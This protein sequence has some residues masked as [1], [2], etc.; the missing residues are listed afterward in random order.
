M[1]AAPVAKTAQEKIIREYFSDIPIMAEVARCESTFVHYKPDGTI[2]QGYVDNRDTGALQ[3]NK[4]Y[5]E[6]TALSMGLNIE[7]FEDNLKYGRHLYETQGLQPWS[8]SKKCW[9]KQLAL[10]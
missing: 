6:A 2:L 1:R 3:I 4:F 10:I 8:A 7:V 9:E 5:H